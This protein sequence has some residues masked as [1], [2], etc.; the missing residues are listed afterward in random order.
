MD[1]T[2][3]RREASS[4]TLP[5]LRELLL[6]SVTDSD[7]D[8]HLRSLRVRLVTEEAR[9]SQR[10]C[11]VF[12]ATLAM[13]LIRSGICVQIEAGTAELLVALPGFEGQTFDLALRRAARLMFPGATL[14]GSTSA[15]VAVLIGSG[16]SPLR[17]ERTITLRA[18]GRTVDLEWS[19]SSSGPWEPANE[20]VALAAAGMAAMEI[21][22][23][24][25]H[26]LE[27]RSGTA[28]QL[29]APSSAS[30]T[31]PF[32]LP[33]VLD[34][35]RLDVISAGAISQNAMWVLASAGARADIRIFDADHIDL[36]NVNRCPYA[37]LD[38]LGRR[39]VDVV[40]ER[41]PER[42]RVEPVARH[43][44]YDEQR[45]LRLAPRVLVGADDIAVR[46]WVQAAQPE[47]I[48]VGATSHFEVV[49]SE[50][51]T[52]WPCAGCI[53]PTADGDVPRLIPTASF[54]SF[55]AGY[56]CGL[57]LL[58]HAVGGPS[59]QD[60]LLTVAFPLQISESRTSGATFRA[61]CPV[62]HRAEV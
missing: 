15:D 31:V 55:W 18:S 20:L 53:H 6:Q 8:R 49:V 40:A 30:F 42:L 61:D 5:L 37:F 13:L 51:M 22:K 25:L 46:H 38:V 47:L 48:V 39:K 2:A 17:A 14:G 57:R 19:R 16:V 58:K 35:G 33:E 4:R 26:G 52:G 28:A 32:D 43:Y 3:D 34:I 27:A 21:H 7:L 41:S 54:V 62:G 56:L 23:L 36:S 1:V 9:F 24:A 44:R 29:L 12:A 45:T 59:Y 10:S 11:Q 50:H 60:G